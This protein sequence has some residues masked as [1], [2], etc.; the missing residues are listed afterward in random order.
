MNT[1]TDEQL[2]QEHRRGQTER[3]ELLVRRYSQELFR[4]AYRLLGSPAAAEDIVQE[5]FLQVH[6]SMERFDVSRRFRPWVFTIAANKARDYLRSQKRRPEVPLDAVADGSSDGGAS[7]SD[8]LSGRSVG[9]AVALEREER[10]SRVRQ[11][12]D[13]LPPH[14]KE[15]LVLGYYHGFAYKEMANVL[16]V[17]IGTIKSRLHSAV[18]KMGDLISSLEPNED[19]VANR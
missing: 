12:V 5:T 16:D 17:P 19:E 13:Q 11:L 14:L 10:S 4:F 9:P 8:L 2:L 1:L 3:F 7:F 18:A 6:L 15:V